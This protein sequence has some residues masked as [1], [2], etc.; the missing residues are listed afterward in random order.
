[1]SDN[2]RRK[3]I[4]TT[5]LG[6]VVLG[7][8][9]LQRGWIKPVVESVT[10]PAHAATTGVSALS[11][12]G[13]SLSY[14]GKALVEHR[15]NQP[16]IDALVTTAHA[17]DVL[18]PA[19]IDDVCIQVTGENTV[20]VSAV[21][22]NNGVILNATGVRVGGRPV[23]M[24]VAPC[25]Q[26]ETNIRNEG[27]NP[28]DVLGIVPAAHAGLRIGVYEVEVDSLGATT[29]QGSFFHTHDEGAIPFSIPAGPC[30]VIDC[31][32]IPG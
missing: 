3:L 2:S 17:G 32:S 24:S 5:A 14:F 6:G 11:A 9:E 8:A 27:I 23:E 26:E 31:G 29:A 22:L 28:M 19:F 12:T 16:L 30:Q 10:L 21:D 4:K 15:S 25:F 13:A 18:P 1:M 20:S 7:A